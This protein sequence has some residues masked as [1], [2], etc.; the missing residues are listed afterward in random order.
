MPA[1]VIVVHPEPDTR[2]L[3]LVT[4][5]AAGH[6]VVGF[7]DPMVTLD[8]VEY[9]SRLRVLVTGIDFGDRK[10]NGVALA[11]M[12]RYKR[13]GVRAVFVASGESSGH[14]EGVGPVLATP[15]DPQALVNVVGDLLSQRD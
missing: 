2:D 13:P 4:L 15:L 14:A 8:T 7:D 1:P 11:R 9:D 3:A 12:L 5:R 10:L 6:E